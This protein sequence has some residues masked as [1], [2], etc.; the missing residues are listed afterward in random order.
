MDAQEKA[1][2]QLCDTLEDCFEQIRFA[3]AAELA[4]SGRYLEAEG[5]LTPNGR[6]SSVPKDLDLLARISAQ[7]RQYGRARRLWETALRQSPGNIDYERAIECA[8][9]AERFQARLRAAAVIA[10]VCL[11]VLAV[12]ISV[13]NF[14]HRSFPSASAD[15]KKPASPLPATPQPAVVAPQPTPATL[16]PPPSTPQPAPTTPQPTPAT[17]QPPASP[18]PATQPLPPDSQ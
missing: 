13:W 5:L 2:Q 12:T 16:Q 4:R 7:R 14:F 15:V 8:K 1:T 3:R 17:L 9:M 6:P 10:F 11:A 18:Q